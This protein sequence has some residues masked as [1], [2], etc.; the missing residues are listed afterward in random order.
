MSNQSPSL[1]RYKSLCLSFVVTSFLISCSSTPEHKGSTF[2][3]SKVK[4]LAFKFEGHPK[5]LNN[6]LPEAE[7]RQTVSSN[8]SEWGYQ[9]ID[10]ESIEYTHDLGIHIGSTRYGSTPVGLSFS[11]GNSDPR[12]LDFQK[13]SVIPLT[14]SLIPK[15][16]TSQRAELVM[17]VLAEEYTGTDIMSVSKEKMITRITDD[18]STTCFNLLSSLNIKTLQNE[19]G[20]K[21]ISPSWMPKIRIEI[22]NIPEDTTNSETETSS[23]KKEISTE[24]RK[25]IIIHNQGTPVI[26]KFG[27]DRK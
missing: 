1:K 12:A 21:I 2:D 4:K 20:E 26:F 22:E 18:I 11:S 14:C 8:L 23:P 25:R 7:I 6:A 9:F 17:E 24:P 13:A 27:P 15:K 5:F 10:K 3:L 16:Q 19:S